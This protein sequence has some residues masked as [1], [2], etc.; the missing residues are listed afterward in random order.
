MNI[1]RLFLFLCFIIYCLPSN[2]QLPFRVIFLLLLNYI[3]ISRLNNKQ[4]IKV[5]MIFGIVLWY[6]LWKFYNNT[7]DSSLLIIT[8]SILPIYYFNKISFNSFENRTRP[9]KYFY[10]LLLC[11]LIQMS[12][13][14]FAG[15]PNLSYEINQSGSYLFLLYLVF[16]LFRF[17]VGKIVIIL[18]SFLLLSRL[19]V[20]CILLYEFIKYL[21]DRKFF[22]SLLN[23]LHLSYTKL[24]VLSYV[25]IG[26]LSFWFIINMSGSLVEGSNDSSRLFNFNDGSNFLRFKI[27]ATI[28]YNIFV[29][30][31]EALVFGGYGNLSEN[32]LYM[33]EYMM[34][35]HNEFF[36]SIAQF[37]L[38]FTLFCFIISKRGYRLL[39]NNNNLEYFIPIVVYTLILWVRF[40]IVTSVEMIFIFIILKLK[41]LKEN[42]NSHCYI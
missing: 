10:F 41:N 4:T 1:Y 19:L 30:Y 34:M 35:P 42:E 37:G 15:R 11:I 29:E 38:L 36:K 2:I 16:S 24:I 33:E 6:I 8:F 27:N 23:L 31:D 25:F 40:C 9:I 20:L 32:K 13:Y 21:K 12:V 39:V 17:R 7:F 22:N 3:V 5:W 14:S 26:V 28:L 18:L